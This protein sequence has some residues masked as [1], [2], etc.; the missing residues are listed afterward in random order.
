MFDPAMFERLADIRGK[1]PGQVDEDL[2]HRVGRYLVRYL[3]E[4][5]LSTER[6]SVLVGRDG[7]HSSPAIYSAVMQGIAREGGK[8]I[9]CGLAT[10]DMVCWGAGRIYEGASVGVMITASHN[11]P[12]YNGIKIVGRDNDSGP[13][14]G[15]ATISP[16]DHLKAYFLTDA[17]NSESAVELDEANELT[18]L[19][20]DF[21][22]WASEWA[23]DHA[24]FNE[25]IVLD[26][27]NGVG[28]LF[29]DPMRKLLPNAEIDTIFEQIDGGFPS[30]PSDPGLPGATDALG[31]KVR[32]SGAAFGAAFD[33]DADRVVLVDE[34]GRFVPGDHLLTA[35]AMSIADGHDG[36]SI[37]F[38]TTCSW[39]LVETIRS[40]GCVPVMSVIGQASVKKAML[41]TRAFFGGES[42]GHFNFADSY[43]QDSGLIALMTIWQILHSTK[44]KLSEVVK[45]LNPIPQSGEINIRVLS[46][47]WKAV[48]SG[49]IDKIAE[50]YRA[51]CYVLG[52]DGASVYSPKCSGIATIDEL[53]PMHPSDP[54]GTNY[55]R[56]H[57]EYRPEWWLSLRKS[58]NEP[59]LRL[60]V[61]CRNGEELESKTRELIEEVRGIC[62]DIGGCKTEVKDWGRIGPPAETP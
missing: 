29:V 58:N 7:R 5:N 52:F 8:P 39:L 4:Q 13:K 57:P 19:C 45:E 34:N 47:D 1:Y 24:I 55:R 48:C 18:G 38:T 9:P 3:D 40:L 31:E 51:E 2:A 14:T 43:F 27:G 32:D 17:D 10:S 30:R 42:S 50:N 61:E 56:I 16:R 44:K 25:K 36:E 35:I 60:N 26:S 33:G 11:P 59:L 6:P 20:E 28:S 23:R 22:R 49:A 53:F 15:L 37:V 41:E 54:S 62:A 12:E 46:D 21:V